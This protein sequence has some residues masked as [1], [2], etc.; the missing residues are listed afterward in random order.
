MRVDRFD[1]ALPEDRIAL[2]PVSPRDTSRM[3]IVKPGGSI[4]DRVT[5][6]LAGLL[7][8]GDALVFNDTKVINAQLSGVRDRDGATA[9]FSATL[10]MRTAPD[11]WLAFVKGAKKLRSGDRVAF[12]TDVLT[13]IVDEKL[14]DGSIRFTFDRQGEHL[15]EALAIVGVVPLP[16][17]IASKR[18]AD[19]RDI[20]D[21]QTVYAEEKG[22]VALTTSYIQEGPDI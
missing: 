18:S 13:A 11:Q 6:E 22:A 19:E 2:R 20:D 7:R 14:A 5:S 9:G 4:E 8:P 3:M 10:H 12:K 21:Y 1:F 17:Y 16:P 15:D